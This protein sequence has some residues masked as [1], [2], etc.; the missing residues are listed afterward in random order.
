MA[1]P[2]DIRLTAIT[3]MAAQG[4]PPSSQLSLGYQLQISTRRKRQP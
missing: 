1:D 3:I 4:V 2:K